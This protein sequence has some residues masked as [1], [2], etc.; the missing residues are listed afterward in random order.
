MPEGRLPDSHPQLFYHTEIKSAQQPP[1]QRKF[2]I[3]QDAAIQD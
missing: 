3:E 2:Q 1:S